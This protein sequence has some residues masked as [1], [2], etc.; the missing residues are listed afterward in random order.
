MLTPERMPRLAAFA[1][2]SL[3]F[4]QARS[5]FPSMTRVATS[6]ISTGTTPAFHGVVGNAFYFPEV[7]RDVV[8][9]TSRAEHLRRAEAVLGAPLLTAPTFADLIAMQG[10]RMAVVHAGSAGSCYA[11]N[12]RV[13]EQGHWTFSILGEAHTR[14]PEANREMVA[15][16]G[17]LPERT[18]P[19]F[20][21]A[22][23]AAR[24]MAEHV[25]PEMKP[26][27]ALIWF[28]E[29]DTSFHYC[30]IGS[31]E[32]AA[33]L[34]HVDA[35]F[36]TI[37]DAIAGQ[38]DAGE[39]AIMVASDHA[40][41]SSTGLLPMRDMLAAA[42]HT[43]AAAADA[44]INGADITFTGGNMGEI[45]V[46]DGDLD[47]RDAIARWL[48]TRD[49]IGMVFTSGDDPV[50]GAA[51]GTL[52]TRLVGLDHARGPDL[53]YVLRSDD[54][55]DAAGL[56]GTC[57]ITDGDVPLGGGMHGG[58]NR[59]EMNTVLMLG[60]TAG[61]VS[62]EAGENGL[63]H[64]IVGIIDIA[65]TILDYLGLSAPVTMMGRSLLGT[66]AH[67]RGIERITHEAGS[68]TFRQRLEVARRHDHLF[69]IHGGRV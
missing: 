63:N 46:I 15:R 27:V 5:V 30:G 3:W 56:P 6:S 25:I 59:H 2:D 17:P 48:M 69:P 4:R 28:S 64:A 65:P 38:P 52:S 57:L 11:I 33:I 7:M 1:V 66:S 34:A 43:A 8:F 26:A 36:G 10:Q 31:P 53:V 60:G 16:F 61:P 35:A 62:T 21:E 20:A 12:P 47:R 13:A 68:G 18:L 23:Y 58:L 40:Q 44:A 14:T 42:G 9:D 19:R 24:V 50:L 37:L 39:I 45:R 32:S 55:M 29:P 41:I 54:R 49:E 67:E 51:P 22:T